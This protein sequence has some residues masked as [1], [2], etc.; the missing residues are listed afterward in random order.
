MP[1]VFLSYAHLDNAQGWI[2]ALQTYLQD[3]VAMLVGRAVDLYR[4]PKLDG[5][6]AVWD[7]LEAQIDA[8]K[9]FVSVLTPRYVRS[10][11]CRRELECFRR[12]TG[13]DIRLDHSFRL[14]RVLKTPFHPDLLPDPL[15]DIDTTGFSFYEIGEHDHALY[16][17]PSD[18]RLPDH[19]KF[20]AACEKLSQSL[21][22]LLDKMEARP[23]SQARKRIFVAETTSDRKSDR[24]FI[25]NELAANY[26]V[27]PR[28]EL[29]K[30]LDPLTAELG[31]ALQN[32]ALSVHLLGATYGVIPDPEPVRSMGSIQAEA[33]TTVKRLVWLPDHLTIT[34]QRQQSFASTLESQAGDNLEF[35]RCSKDAFL[36]H[37]RDV[38]QELEEPP[39]P[40]VFGKAVYLVSNEDDLVQA[41]FR[42]LRKCLLDAGVIVEQPAF[43]G[44]L[45]ELTQAERDSLQRSNA[46]LIYY[47]T[48]RDVWVRNR[49]VALLKALATIE[50]GGIHDRALYLC[51]PETVSKRGVY[52]DLPG[53]VLVEA[54]GFK[55]LVILGNCG[56]FDGNQLQPL[57]QRLNASAQ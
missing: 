32:C 13:R 3:R 25:V 8:A 6:D 48:A 56:E 44:D 31:V 46:T 9:L 28:A 23:V 22:G 55:P 7:T 52:M 54:S 38:L 21:A 35:L 15:T 36:S 34:D 51:S 19:A 5:A 42:A 11:S 10:E 1:D 37:L 4:D 30:D 12:V 40:K 16:E 57:F 33:A 18:A 47:G 50:N 14:I 27:T 17:F 2:T 29:S 53:N 41:P 49:R 24:A 26:E 45:N 20:I 43:E 39:P